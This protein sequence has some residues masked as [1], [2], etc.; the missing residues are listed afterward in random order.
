MVG[1]LL[2]V[3]A[4][5]PSWVDGDVAYIISEREREL[6][7]SL[8]TEDERARFIR[9]FWARRDPNRTTP[10]NEFRDEHER[11]V[12]YANEFLGRE[13]F[14]PGWRT[15]RGRYYILLGEPRSIHRFYGE[16]ALK[17]AEL[18]FYQGLE[19]KG[20]P[21]FFYLLFFKPDEVG[22]YRL[23]HPFADG[24]ASLLR[25]AVRDDGAAVAE[26]EAIDT[27]LAH[28]SLSLDAGEPPDLVNARPALG[29]DALLARI[30][31]SPE[32]AVDTRYVD[33][34]RE[35]GHRV[36]SADYSFNWVPSRHVFAVMTTADG[37]PIVHYG[38]ELDPESFGLETDEGQSRYYT[39]LDVSVEVTAAN[40]VMVH[41][42]SRATFIELTREQVEAI[43]TAPVAYQDDF[44]LVPG[45]YTVSVYL[46]N[47]ALE[48]WTVAEAELHIP[49][50]APATITD[51]IL[52]RGVSESADAVDADEV[53]TFQLGS[54]KLQ[55]AT[56]NVVAAGETVS[57]LAHVFDPPAGATTR[58]ELVDGDAIHDTA[59]GARTGALSTLGLGG[60]NYE[61]RA[62]LVGADGTTLAEKGTS[63]TI[64]PRTSVPAPGFVYRRGFNT[65]VPGLLALVRGDQ[66]WRLSRFDEAQRSYE[67]A[68]AANNPDLPQ[69]RW[70]LAT[71][72]L[73][74]GDADAA[75]PLLLPL[76]KQHPRQFEVV[77]GLGLG[78][79]LR[80]EHARA[81]GYLERALELR[82]PDTSLLNALGDS[83]QHL[84]NA[85]EARRYFERSLALDPDQ[86][87]VEKRL[88]QRKP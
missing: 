31:S 33:A 68:V 84:G 85:G 17:E 10:E 14:V 64:S 23:Y 66:L 49:E 54:T 63:L 60:G 43:E 50:P 20:L 11:R 80:G 82:P 46:Q 28:A 57:V 47:R 18:W 52:A 55:P 41:A 3:L 61:V 86:D 77:A 56:G 74:V 51:I 12:G 7:L 2:A 21:A 48:N 67:L 34:W 1:I 25:G 32:R 15:D 13:S 59:T 6:F 22:D 87:A 37:T 35:H 44:P 72:L 29:V 78:F 38:L 39:T 9:A 42:S 62:R 76:E 83:H 27:E 4:A 75:L 88:G 5:A 73:R 65:R 24:P 36:A 53:R 45:R 69:A 30:E 71:A 70:K 40:G 26:L 58:F 79:Y 16:N 81:V 19:D 8:D